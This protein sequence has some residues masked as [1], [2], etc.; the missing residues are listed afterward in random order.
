MK[1]DK[2]IRVPKKATAQRSSKAAI[3]NIL[4]HIILTDRTQQYGVKEP[5]LRGDI[6]ASGESWPTPREYALDLM[7]QLGSPE[8]ADKLRRETEAK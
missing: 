4:E 1:C 3:L 6:P 8:E 2:L 7:R 5:N